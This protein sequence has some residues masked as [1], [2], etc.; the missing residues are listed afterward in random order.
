MPFN[1]RTS[2]TLIYQQIVVV[3][4]VEMDVVVDVV[5]DVVTK[6]NFGSL[7]VKVTVT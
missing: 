4:T 6:N 3:E 2:P 7:H 1:Y 5:V